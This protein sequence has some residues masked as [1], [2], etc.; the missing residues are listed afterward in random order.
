MSSGPADVKAGNVSCIQLAT[1]SRSTSQPTLLELPIGG[2]KEYE[3]LVYPHKKVPLYSI[4]W[5]IIFFCKL[6][7]FYPLYGGSENVENVKKT[8]FSKLWQKGDI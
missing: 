7:R 4:I 3:F 6:L 5:S 1:S 2:G 8:E